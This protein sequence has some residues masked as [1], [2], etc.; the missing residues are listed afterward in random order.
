MA[1]DAQVDDYY[2]FLQISPNADFETIHRVYRFLATRLHPD[3][4]ETGQEERFRLLKTAY[5]VLSDPR[6][7]K[8]YDIGRAQTQAPPK[9]LAETVD[10]MDAME[11]ETNRRLAVLAVLYYKRRTN[12]IF[13]DVRLAEI[14]ERM[15]F[16][17]DYLDFTL[18]YLQKKGY[19]TKSDN[20]QYALSVEGVDFVESERANT[21]TLQRL[22]TSGAGSLAR[23]VARGQY[24]GTPEAGPE[25]TV[26]PDATSF[27]PSQ[28]QSAEQPPMRASGPIVLPASMSTPE[29][30]RQSKRDRRVGKPD[31]REKK[32][33]R[34]FRQRDR[35]ENLDAPQ[36]SESPVLRAA[37]PKAFSSQ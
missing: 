21:P 24:T 29:E 3:N 28:R 19:V 32:G 34:R 8:E 18:W 2:E 10:F 14:E 22:L 1:T 36:P 7:R 37:T 23:D 6:R 31:L 35:R 33:E 5:D 13:P 4:N 26:A 25:P 11:G 9:P 30:R 16:P 15:G 17:R 12:P 20:A 27:R